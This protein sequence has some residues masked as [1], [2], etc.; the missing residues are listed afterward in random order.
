MNRFPDQ[1]DLVPADQHLPE[2][3]GL[4]F[5]GVAIGC[6]LVFIAYAIRLVS[7]FNQDE[8]LFAGGALVVGILSGFLEY[9]RRRLPLTLVPMGDEVGA[10]RAGRFVQDRKSVV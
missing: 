7:K 8:A 9:R 3:I 5:G 6:A 1:L 2:K 4:G 10:Y